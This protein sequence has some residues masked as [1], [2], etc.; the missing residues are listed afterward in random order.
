MPDLAAAQAKVAEL[1]ERFELNPPSSEAAVRIEFINPF[2]QALGWDVANA[3]GYADQYKEVVHE[4]S[5]LVGTATKAPDYSFRIGGIRKFFVEAKKPSVCRAGGPPP[6][7][8]AAKIARPLG[9]GDCLTTVVR[10][11]PILETPST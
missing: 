2:F 10:T 4:D 7:C 5:V 6:H 11:T 1:V 9:R 8:T 3:A